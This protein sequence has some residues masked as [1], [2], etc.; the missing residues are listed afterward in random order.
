MGVFRGFDGH[1]SIS[2]S[3][4]VEKQANIIMGIP[5]DS[6]GN[7]YKIRDLSAITWVPETP[8]NLGL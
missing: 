4:V 8:G 5:T 2:G 6:L 7:P 3:K 1:S